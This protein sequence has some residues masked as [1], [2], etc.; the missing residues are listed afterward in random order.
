MGFLWTELDLLHEDQNLAPD[1]NAARS[2]I[3]RLIAD[4]PRASRTDI[5]KVTG[6]ARSTID[7]HLEVLVGSGLVE[8]AGLG[9]PDARGRPAQ[10]FKISD[11]KGVL[12]VADVSSCLTRMALTT[13]DKEVVA[14][15]DVDL[16]VRDG[17]DRLLG[18]LCEQFVTL[19]GDHGWS[20]HDALAVSVGL[21]GPVDSHLG[22]AV[23]PPLMPGW[24]GHLVC[25]PLAQFFGCDVIVDNDTNLAALGE[26]RAYRGEHLPLLMVNI[27]TGVGGGFVGENGRLLH[28]ADGAATDIGHVQVPDAVDAL[29][30][31]G[32]RGCLE[33]V[34]SVGAMAARLSRQQARDVSPRDLIDSLVRGDG[35][36]VQVVRE[37]ASAVGRVVSNLVNFSNPRRIVIGGAITQVTE[38]VLAQVRS[39]V[40][41]QAQPLATRNL[42][43][44]HSELG[45]E[46]G[47]IGG[48][49][50]VIE[51]VLSPRGIAYHT[52]PTGSTM[53][54]LGL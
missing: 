19:L 46:A 11:R 45:D 24:D 43:L 36:T 26:A 44:V 51:Q 16:D 10:V 37:A 41:Q 31:C 40:Y 2:V 48:M 50:S 18:A 8:D 27:G 35:A 12:L 3:A 4:R 42:S 9:A 17:P 5:V 21:P 38:D 32:G 34:A 49:V 54:P 23:R 28:G 7:K 20:R 30:R 13:L 47:L 53:K 52:R 33:A 1:A 15:R 22:M 6:L 25:R 29:C 14:R 39:V